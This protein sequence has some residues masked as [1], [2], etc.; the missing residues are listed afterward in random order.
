MVREKEPA[1]VE[2]G[3][4]CDQIVNTNLLHLS[5]YA[6]NVNLNPQQRIEITRSVW[7]QMLNESGD[8]EP[9]SFS[10]ERSEDCL[11]EDVRINDY[12]P[13]MKAICEKL[14]A[15]E[16]KVSLHVMMITFIDSAGMILIL[17]AIFPAKG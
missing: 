17:F 15:A 10:N 2:N 12:I 7:P 9:C 5:R 8:A 1:N 13:A 11:K 6:K 16:N 4:K 3:L 14:E